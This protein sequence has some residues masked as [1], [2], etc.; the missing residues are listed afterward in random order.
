MPS[1]L[2][3]NPRV[4]YHAALE[5]MEAARRAFTGA[6]Y[7]LS[8]YLSGLAVEC[9]LQAVVLLDHPS[10]DARHDLNKWLARTRTSLQ[11]AIKAPD[12]RAAWSLLTAVWRNGLRYLSE[13]G[14]V[15]YLRGLDLQHGIAGGPDAI[16]KVNARKLLSASEL[17]LARG[18]A[19]WKTY[20][21]R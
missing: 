5:R 15:G 16:M 6:D 17:V 4:L 7:V 13:S 21:T 20:T 9:V 12:T 10:H 18:V 19:A 2:S 11:V 14:L 8:M 1:L 3:H